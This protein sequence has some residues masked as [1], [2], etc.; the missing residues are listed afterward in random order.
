M[1]IF[2][3]NWLEEG[4]YEMDKYGDKTRLTSKEEINQAFKDN[5]LYYTDGSGY[6]LD[7]VE[8]L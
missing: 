7:K 6:G 1:A 3:S 5:K 4:Y 8:N 2:G